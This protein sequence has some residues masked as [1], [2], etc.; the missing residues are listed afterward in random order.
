LIFR[1]TLAKKGPQSL[2]FLGALRFLVASTFEIQQAIAA[3]DW[4]PDL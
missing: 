4:L 3:I 2:P 1:E